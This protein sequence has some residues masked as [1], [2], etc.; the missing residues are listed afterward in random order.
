MAACISL[1]AIFSGTFIR[2]YQKRHD[3]K[4]TPVVHFIQ[5]QS[6]LVII[7]SALFQVAFDFFPFHGR[8]GVLFINLVVA[9]AQSGSLWTTSF[10]F[11][12]S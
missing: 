12:T 8:F 7:A 3:A 1:L 10:N 4:G 2:M 11:L 9:G 6:V 5:T